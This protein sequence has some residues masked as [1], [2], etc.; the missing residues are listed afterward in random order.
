MK[1]LLMATD[2]SA[3]S[4]RALVRAVSTAR[5]TGANLTVLHVVDDALPPSAADAQAQ[6]AHAAIGEHIESLTKRGRPQVVIDVTVGRRYAQIFEAAE[7]SNAEMIVLGMHREGAL[8]DMFRGTTVERVIRT[9]HLPVLLV[10][11]RCTGPYRRVVIG[12]DFSVCS[13]KAIEFAVGLLPQADFQLIHAYDIPFKGF[14]YS[15]RTRTAAKEEHRAKLDKI[16]GTEMKTLLASLRGKRPRLTPVLQEG[17]VW[18]VLDRQI[19]RLKPDL[20]VIGTHGRTGAAHALL[21][22]VAE[23]L[24]RKP[25]CD[26]LAV[27]GW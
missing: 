23:D 27:K 25:P 7:K 10:K 12:V 5:E 6:F 9:G 21:G 1:N 26:V 20:L 3:R 18:S 11:D 22:S 24:L 15:E 2:L 16:V 19:R 17:T 14:G 8:K 13:R 4:D